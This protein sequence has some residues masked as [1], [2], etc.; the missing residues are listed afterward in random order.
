MAN[1]EKKMQ[2]IKQAKVQVS[3]AI[4]VR[5]NLNALLRDLSTEN[6]EYNEML[7][8]YEEFKRLGNKYKGRYSF[9][10]PRAISPE[11]LKPKD[12]KYWAMTRLSQRLYKIEEQAAAKSLVGRIRKILSP[13]SA[14]G[15]S[16]LPLEEVVRFAVEVGVS[17]SYLLQPIREWLENDSLLEFINFGPEGLVISAREWLL[18]VHGLK[19]VGGVSLPDFYSQMLNFSAEKGLFAD[20]SKP[21][22]LKEERDRITNAKNSPIIPNTDGKRFPKYGHQYSD[23]APKIPS[24]H[25]MDL[26]PKP[27]S[28]MKRVHAR[29][30]AAIYL[31]HLMRHAFLVADSPNLLSSRKEDIEWYLNELRVA[32]SEL[33]NNATPV[34]PSITTKQKYVGMQPEQP[35]QPL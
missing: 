27:D 20:S 22:F 18:Y 17:P 12:D 5:L 33:A 2:T 16:D 30:R 31:L 7:K 10:H 32:F 8:E 26:L 23:Y 1:N 6:Q 25:P 15:S 21:Y 4:L 28:Y 35:E 29:T 24:P 19:G 14:K 11:G 13:S 9:T 34:E 3:C